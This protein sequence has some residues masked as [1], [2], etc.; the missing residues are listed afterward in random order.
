MHTALTRRLQ[1]RNLAAVRIFKGVAYPKF[2]CAMST[3]AKSQQQDEMVA[4]ILK[5]LS[6]TP[7]LRK[8]IKS[9]IIEA[10][11][12]SLEELT[13]S[14]EIQEGGIHDLEC[15]F[16][17][18]HLCLQRLEDQNNEFKSTIDQLQNEINLLE[19]YTRR[20]SLCISVFWRS[21]A[22]IPNG[23]TKDLQRGRLASTSYPPC[24]PS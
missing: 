4:T 8:I 18:S 9:A 17:D 2:L 13:K 5:S 16:D 3:R 23:S 12:S 19:Q 21:L 7:D 20:N 6:E 1:E 24:G 22:K 14:L 11:T 10:M 15:K